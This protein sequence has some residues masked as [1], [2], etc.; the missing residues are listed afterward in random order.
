MVSIDHIGATPASLR[1]AHRGMAF[2]RIQ[3]EPGI[4]RA[5]LAR[6]LGF[7]EMASTRIVREL[8]AAGL[9][10]EFE[11]AATA[12][13]KRKTLGR[14]KTGLRIID[15]GLFAVG[16]IVSAYHSE[17]SIC[18][19]AGTI[20]ATRRVIDPPFD[21]VQG[22]ARLYARAVRDLIAETGIDTD[23][24]VGIGVALSARTDPASATILKS[25]YFGW[26]NDAGLFCRELQKIVDLPVEIEN[27]A[28]ALAI[29]EMRFGAARDVRTFSLVH[30]ATFIGASMVS[31]GRIVR[32]A[33]GISGL[34][35]HFRSEQRA[36]TCV[37]GR[38]DCLNLTAS[39]FGLLSCM[40]RLDGLSFDRSRLNEY[41]SALMEILRDSAGRTCVGDA[42]AM[43]APAID[44]MA[45]LLGPEIV[46]V[47]GNLGADP[48][49]FE[50]VR[51]ALDRDFDLDALQPF[52]LIRGTIA[53]ERSAA[54]LALHAF[55]YS[56]RLDFDRF[57][58]SAPQ[59]RDALG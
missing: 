13:R 33:T 27:I 4:S 14:P 31:E 40:G 25:E 42:G 2:S 17:V 3:R 28:N 9:V 47:S 35:G 50:G 24:L 54:L 12:T 45:K 52:R 56:D 43:L 1:R 41:A 15:D 21:S 38:H 26:S 18:D 58:R 48:V 32:G 22:T 29:A 55:G 5:D 11:G 7:S 34:M 49:Y 30:A 39:G 57:S 19:A 23:R 53:S 6:T 10:E 8:L 36:L 37:C 51:A 16:I 59:E 44:S 20:R 46:I